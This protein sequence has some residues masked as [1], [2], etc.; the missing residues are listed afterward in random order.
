MAEAAM[1]VTK[2]DAKSHDKPDEVR[3]P[4]KTRVEVVRLPGYTLARMNME[5]G[6]RWS[7][8]VK[9]VVKTESCQLSHV[10]YV[11]SGTITVRMNDGTQMSF[12]EGMS[13][14]IPPGHD[15]WVEGKVPFQ[16]IEVLSAEQYAKLA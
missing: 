15:A 7:E 11:V 4:A 3:S 10:G 12:S 8:C 2:L 16:C 9:P 14:T 13:Y 6:W 1:N 5:P